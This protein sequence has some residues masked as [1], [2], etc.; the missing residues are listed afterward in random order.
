[1]ARVLS[2]DGQP[3]VDVVPRRVRIG[4]DLV[5][6]L[7]ETLGICAIEAGHI[8]VQV[9]GEPEAAFRLAEMRGRSAR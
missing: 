6:R 7:D 2:G 5:R 8:H 9:D 1:M 3:H 4:A